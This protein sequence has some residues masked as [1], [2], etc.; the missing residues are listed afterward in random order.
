MNGII[1]I[2][3][4]IAGAAREFPA[5]NRL[6]S[7]YFHQDWHEEY[8][9]TASAVNAFLHDAP[10]SL[11][12][13]AVADIDA[14]LALRLDDEALGSVLRDGFEC[15]YVPAVDEVGNHQWLRQLRALLQT[16]A[17]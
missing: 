10:P 14:L 17:G 6:F 3:A 9:T 15:N 1:D 12:N 5:L 2:N 7:A 4:T 11:V 16:P 8:D 13:S